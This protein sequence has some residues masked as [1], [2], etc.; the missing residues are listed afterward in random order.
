LFIDALVTAHVLIVVIVS[1][2]GLVFCWKV[3][4]SS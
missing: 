4:H 3:S 2:I 1:L